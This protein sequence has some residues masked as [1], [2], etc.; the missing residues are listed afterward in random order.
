MSD[1]GYTILAYVVGLG[2][3]WGYGLLLLIRCMKFDSRR[4]G[5]ES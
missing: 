2:L 3:T 5:A 1:V 4:E